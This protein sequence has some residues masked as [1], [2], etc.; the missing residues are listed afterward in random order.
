[1][2]EI[3]SVAADRLWMSPS[4]GR[5]TVCIHF[6]W[7][8]EPEAVGGAIVRLEAALAPFGARPHWGKLFDADAGPGTQTAAP[9]R[10]SA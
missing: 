10:R 5:E 6:T 1:M 8:P 7:K 2:T 9:R 4:Y 3:R